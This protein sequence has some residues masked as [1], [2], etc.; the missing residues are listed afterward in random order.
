MHDVWPMPVPE[1]PV[2][3]VLRR[4]G[5]DPEWR[6]PPKGCLIPED[7]YGFAEHFEENQNEQPQAE[8]YLPERIS[9]RT[10]VAKRPASV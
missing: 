8:P 5:F 6:H 1:L 3:L 7:R 4:Q 2:Q 9:E 10:D